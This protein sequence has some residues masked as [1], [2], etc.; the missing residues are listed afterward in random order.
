VLAALAH[1]TE[2]PC[3]EAQAI[4]EPSGGGWNIDNL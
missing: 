4:C 3:V 2:N 1:K